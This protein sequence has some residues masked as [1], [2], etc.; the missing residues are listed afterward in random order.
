MALYDVQIPDWDV[1]DTVDVYDHEEA[2]EKVVEFHHCEPTDAEF[3][4]G[5]NVLVRKAV[6]ETDWLPYTVFPEATIRYMAYLDDEVKPGR[7]Q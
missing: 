6:L 1:K 2:A 3:Y 5:I 4:H 7:S